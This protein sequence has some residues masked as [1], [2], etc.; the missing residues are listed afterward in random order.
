MFVSE[1]KADCEGG[2]GPRKCL[3]VRSKESEPWTFFYSKIEGFT[4]EEGTK[5]QL[6]VATE[7]RPN[8]PQDASSVKYK[9]V[10]IVSQ[11]KVTK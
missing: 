2:E 8:P 1:K 11:E 6:E 5:Y 3:Q 10:K 4:Y 7:P 9:L